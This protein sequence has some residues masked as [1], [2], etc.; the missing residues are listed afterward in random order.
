[1]PE[2]L[3]EVL[4]RRPLA[5]LSGPTFAGEVARG[6]PTAII[7]A[8][9]DDPRRAWRRRSAAGAFRPYWTDDVTGVVVGGA[10]KNVIAIACGIVDGRRL[11]DNAR[12]R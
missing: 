11:G 8:A 9:E 1:M 12:P 3:G 10:V 6:L 2:V 7:A 5:V 4:P